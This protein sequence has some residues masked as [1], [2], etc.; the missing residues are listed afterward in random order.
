MEWLRGI[1][2][3]DSVCLAYQKQDPWFNTPLNSYC[4]F[5][6]TSIEQ[7][8]KV[9]KHTGGRTPYTQDT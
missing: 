3:Y 9:P 2:V 4:W 1:H 7:I 6:F 8:L 5:N